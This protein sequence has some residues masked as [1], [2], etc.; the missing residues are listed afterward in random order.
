MAIDHTL[1]IIVTIVLTVL[2][3]ADIVAVALI[4]TLVLGLKRLAGKAEE[5]AE[6][7]R[8]AALSFA[9][10]MAPAAASGIIAMAIKQWSKRKSKGGSH[11]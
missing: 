8:G 5:A 4:I 7:A 6:D 2:V 11:E 1:F 10:R 3:V 9:K